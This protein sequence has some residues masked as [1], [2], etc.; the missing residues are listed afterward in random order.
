M[1]GAALWEPSKHPNT[2]GQL[3]ARILLS[4]VGVTGTAVGAGAGWRAVV[5]Y[6]RAGVCI[7]GQATKPGRKRAQ[8]ACTS[9][10]KHSPHTCQLAP[11]NPAFL[12]ASL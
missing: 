3:C 1:V 4:H 6:A 9:L 7:G 12:Q 10:L 5:C 8:P 11:S 2:L